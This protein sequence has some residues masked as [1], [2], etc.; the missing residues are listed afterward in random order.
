MCVCFCVSC[1]CVCVCVCVQAVSAAVGAHK[2]ACTVREIQEALSMEAN[3]RKLLRAIAGML[4]E[5]S[6]LK[7]GGGKDEAVVYEL[8]VCQVR[9]RVR[10]RAC[11]CRCGPAVVVCQLAVRQVG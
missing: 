10:V 1:V 4:V 8:A 5:D 3:A 2:G 7:V 6:V 9:G 11:V